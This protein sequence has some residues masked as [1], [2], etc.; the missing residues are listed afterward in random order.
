MGGHTG[1]SQNSGS[2]SFLCVHLA[3]GEYNNNKLKN[4]ECYLQLRVLR[5]GSVPHTPNWGGRNV[6]SFP[7]PG[8]GYPVCQLGGRYSRY[9][10]PRTGHP[11]PLDPSGSPR[12][13]H[14]SGSPP[15]CWFVKI[16]HG[17]TVQQ[18]P[19]TDLGKLVPNEYKA[20]VSKLYT[21]SYADAS[22]TSTTPSRSPS[23]CT[24]R[25]R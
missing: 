21:R 15:T 25:A 10:P 8:G 3:Q 17:P 1:A 22:T 20:T 5:L 2:Q 16:P 4:N 11:P 19:V 14:T 13:A 6:S 23:A 12:A 7:T 24:P 9:P 18:S